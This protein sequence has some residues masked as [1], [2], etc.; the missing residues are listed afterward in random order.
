MPFLHL[1]KG[2]LSLVYYFKNVTYFGYI[3]KHTNTIIPEDRF[4]LILLLRD[5]SIRMGGKMYEGE[6]SYQNG[7]FNLSTLLK[8]EY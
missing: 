8:S 7:V 3:H 4:C 6:E 2:F 1:S 5:M